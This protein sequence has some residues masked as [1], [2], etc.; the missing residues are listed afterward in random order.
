MSWYIESL[1]GA[2]FGG[3]DGAVNRTKTLVKS[4]IVVDSITVTLADYPQVE[5]GGY[6]FDSAT[7]IITLLKNVW[8]DFVIQIQ[9]EY[10]SASVNSPSNDDL[11]YTTILKFNKFLMM[12]QHVPNRGQETFPNKE[13]VGTGDDSVTEF[14]FDNGDIIEN[15][16][17]LY[18]G[19]TEAT[20]TDTLTRDTH[21]TLDN[22]TGIIT[23]TS[24]GVTLLSTNTI[25]SIYDYNKYEISNSRIKDALLAAESDIDSKVNTVFFDGTATTPDFN[26]VKDELHIG[27]GA[28]LSSY[29]FDNYPVFNKTT[30]LDGAVS[31]DDGT[32]TVIST[33]GFPSSGY[34]AIESDKISYTG[35]TG[36]TFTGCSSVSAHDDGTTVNSVVIERS[37]DGEGMVPTW[38]VMQHDLDYSINFEAGNMNLN[39]TRISQATWIDNFNPPLGVWDRVRVSYQSG[40]DQ[41]YNDIIK[42]VHLIA[43]SE[44][45]DAGVLNALARKTDGFD[46][47]SFSDIQPRINKILN[48]YECWLITDTKP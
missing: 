2:D 5:G 36:T 33:A 12:N 42:A 10:D 30:T 45:F 7:N 34:I 3:S 37:V 35:K 47:G 38:V 17:T 19:A 11:R 1:T 29:K 22:D 44:L 13:E 27:R 16:E 48:K 28:N 40:Y 15:T 39:N 23:L 25:Y 18:Y 21:Y 14:T 8:N 26:I 20:A 31:A 4:G 9:Y 43:G 41:I 32:I 46:T 24:A 6:T